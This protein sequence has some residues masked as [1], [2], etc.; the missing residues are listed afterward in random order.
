LVSAA[1]RHH[2]P[3]DIA[4]LASP[5]IDTPLKKYEK[6]VKQQLRTESLIQRRTLTLNIPRNEYPRP[7]LKRPDW[8]CLNGAWT[9]S[10]D[11][12][13]SGGERG[14]Q[15]SRGFSDEILVP[16]CPE[17]SLS[18]VGHK[19]F[20][21]TIWYQRSLE[22]P[23]RWR[24]MRIFLH[25]GGVDYESEVFIDGISIGRHWGGS[26]SFSF[27]ITPYVSAGA[28]HNLVVY[29]RDDTR[30]GVQPAGKQSPEYRFRKRRCHY[31]RTTGIWQTV[32]ME[33]VH[34]G[35][36]KSC[37]LI[38]DLDGGRLIVVP[39]YHSVSNGLS[40]HA[41]ARTEGEV[42]AEVQVTAQQGVPAT[43]TLENCRPWE[44]GSPFLYDIELEVRE[45]DNTLDHVDSYAGIRKVALEGD[46][47]LLNNEPIYLRL[48]L[49][50]GFYPDGVWTAPK[51]DDLK[52]D[53][54][55]SM[56]AGF[57]GARLHQ[58]VFEERFHYWADR[59]G[60]LTWGESASWGI[61][62]TDEVSAR[63]FLSEWREVVI[64]DRN[65]P[66]IIAWTPLNETGAIAANPRQHNRFHADLYDLT[67]AL[68]PTRPVNDTS[69]YIHVKTD[70]WTVHNYAQD[71]KK[72]EED[73]RGKDGQGVYRRHDE[74]EPEYRGQ[75]YLI[76]EF[77]GMLWI[78]PERKP[79]LDSSWGYGEGP[80]TLEEL[81]ERLSA[82][83]DVIL[84]N[85][86]ICGFCYT[87]LTDVEQE[88]NG[89]Y[90]FD[91]SAKFDMERISAIFSRAQKKR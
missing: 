62:V 25:W 86:R 9:Y 71:P 46:R 30:S 11:F 21:E 24:D 26:G 22:V 13:K 85:R 84:G 2:K 48:V 81:Y 35:G 80:K 70:L 52:R 65:H 87:Q 88:Q 76:D 10:F 27:D 47:I 60:Y 75:P 89:I 64:R 72:L 57:N 45:G 42:I 49:D 12:G 73:L 90:C 68:D 18:G 59:L 83:V 78:S 40:L 67:H 19:D 58:K 32:W 37:Q 41:A 43:L 6:L 53:I 54:E 56:A 20:I 29:A 63:N 14:F 4:I 61:T 44:P 3:Y 82:L 38:P 55:L 36:L 28:T 16:F 1:N 74:W 15:E 5:R 69:G 91:R 7:Q 34:P 39:T 33:A 66:S 79:Y 50:Q 8:I 17:S 31:T 51:E 77:G 23:E